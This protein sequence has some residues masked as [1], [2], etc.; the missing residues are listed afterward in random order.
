M[1]KLIYNLFYYSYHIVY[2]LFLAYIL[3]Y[4]IFL[5]SLSIYYTYLMI[6][7]GGLLLGFIFSEEASKYLKKYTKKN[8][9]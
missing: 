9:G 5:R 4:A 2:G 1:K 6:F 3:L 8:N 7:I